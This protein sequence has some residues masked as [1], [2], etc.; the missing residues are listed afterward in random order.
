MAI[1]DNRLLFTNSQALTASAALADVIDLSQDRDLGPGEP[2]YWWLTTL[3][4]SDRTDN[5]ETYTFALQTDDN[6]GFSS[7]DT[8]LSFSFPAAS[9][10]AGRTFCFALPFHVGSNERYLRAYATLGGTTP[11][12]TVASGLSSEPVTAWQAYPAPAQA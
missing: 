4:A 5:N 11:S 9:V 8:I 7:P 2:V 1:R 3:T 10:P 6:P 12:V